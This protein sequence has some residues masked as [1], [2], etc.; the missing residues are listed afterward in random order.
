MKTIGPI[1]ENTESF[2]ISEIFNQKENSITYIGKDEREIIN[3]KKKLKWLLPKQKILLFKAWDQIPYDNI[4]PSKEVQTS[5]LETLYYLNTKTDEKIIILTTINAIIQKIIPKYELKK[6]YIKISKSSKLKIDELLS[7][8]IKLGYERVSI[9]RDKSEFAVRGSIID[10]FL[11]QLKNP[12]RIDLFDNDIESIFE[13]DVITQTRISNSNLNNLTINASTELIIDTE[14]LEKFRSNFRE[15]FQ[16]YRKSQVYN[17]FSEGIIPSGGEQYLPLFNK[18]LDTLFDY[19][20]QNIFIVNNDI[21][22]L[23]EERIENLYDYYNARIDSNDSFYLDPSF[24]F[25]DKKNFN[26]AIDNFE[27]IKLSPFYNE[28]FTK[29]NLKKIN[30]LSSIRKEI[31]FDF[32]KKFFEINSKQNKIIICCNS[33]GSLEKVFKILSENIFIS[34]IEIDNY[35]YLSDEKLFITVLKIEES[36]QLHNTIYINEKA[37]FGYSLAVKFSQKKQKKKFLFEE[38]N[39][40]SH[41]SLLVHSDYGICRFNNI[42]KI[43]LDDFVHDCLEL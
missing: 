28:G 33:K 42:K 9:V 4:S 1:I 11:P 34:P 22:E 15:K 27:L 3:I 32:I 29:T 25:I 12:I 17:L 43:N 10:I 36:F 14:H 23:F 13:F 24:L 38:L 20:K 37:I 35:N 31:D 19:L 6:N 26:N 8:L 16:D 30:N 40:L 2:L 18:K 41:G 7:L 21:N 39:K 5:R